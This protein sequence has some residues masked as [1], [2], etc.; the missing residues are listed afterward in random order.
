[1]KKKLLAL[2]LGSS[3]VLALAACGGGDD[4]ATKEKDT[5]TTGGETTTADA[6]DAEKLFNQKCSSC[7][8][9]NL[10]G[11]V[12]PAL[13]KAGSTHSKEDIESIIANGQG[14]MPA[15]LLSGDEATQVAEWLA[16]KK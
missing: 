10:E 1:M 2:L 9:G 8:G 7:H 11:G 16:A 5:G 12:G 3:L 4:D 13:D 14:A 6:G 15:G